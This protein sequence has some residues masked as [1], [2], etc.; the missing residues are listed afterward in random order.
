MLQSSAYRQ[1]AKPRDS[2]SRSRSVSRILDNSGDSTPLTQKVIWRIWG[3]PAVSGGGW[4]VTGRGR[5]NDW[6][7]VSNNEAVIADQ[8]V[9]DDESHDSLPFDDIERVGRVSQSCQKFCES[10]RQ[11]QEHGA[12]VGLVGDC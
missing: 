8:N 11:A 2:N 4:C 12:V 10:L 5:R 7:A 9:L 1:N 6:N 3:T